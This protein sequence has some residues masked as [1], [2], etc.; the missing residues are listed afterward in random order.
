MNCEAV[1][2]KMMDY[3]FTELDEAEQ[4]LIADH[5]KDC[6]ACTE[7]LHEFRAT[8]QIMEKWPEAKSAQELVFVTPKEN[9]IG[10]W[11]KPFRFMPSIPEALKWIGRLA[12][13][14]AVLAILVFRTEISYQNGQFSF[15]FG[16]KGTT[17]TTT[18][19]ELITAINQLQ[20]Q[21]IYLM[22]QMIAASEN[23]Q[24]ELLLTGLSELSRQI[25]RQ[26]ATDIQYV[27]E[28]LQRIQRTNA[29]NFNRT[30]SI[31]EGLVKV[32]SSSYPQR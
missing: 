20:Q 21:N 19:P 16:G 24:K 22:S 2:N 4:K 18:S 1:K 28:N 26:R 23:R 31:L 13:G 25:D 29:Y 7:E 3:L 15:A 6:A 30:N 5:L 11:F 8:V 17:A 10:R 32:T 27:G 14:A 12:V 9:F